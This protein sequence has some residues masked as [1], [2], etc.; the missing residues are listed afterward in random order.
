MSYEWQ[1]YMQAENAAR[2]IADLEQQLAA[3]RAKVAEIERQLTRLADCGD[4]ALCDV[5]RVARQAL[6]ALQSTDALADI[7]RAVAR[8]CAEI[9]MDRATQ[10]RKMLGAGT[11]NPDF[12]DVRVDALEKAASAIRVRFGVKL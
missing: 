1:E 9:L 5:R 7:R 6:T 8:E 11:I 3:E 4:W 12:W 10:C 2:H